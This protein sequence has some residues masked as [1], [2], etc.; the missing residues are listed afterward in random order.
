MAVELITKNH[1]E[2]VKDILDSTKGKVLIISPFMGENTCKEL[3]NVISKNDLTC[4]VITRFYREDF[5]QNVS[6]LDGLLCLLES[7][8]DLRSLK[9]LHTKLYIF[10]DNC[11]IITS[12]NY[13]NGGFFSNI[14]LG[15]KIDD[16]FEINEKCKDYFDDLWKRI[17]D[18]NKENNNEAVITKELI[19][20]EK[21][22]VK[23]CKVNR[24]TGKSTKDYNQTRRGAEL[25]KIHSNDLFEEAL[26]HKYT[27][28]EFGGWLKFNGNSANRHDPDREYF[29]SARDNLFKRTRIFSPT[30]PIG[31]KSG[32]RIFLA[33]LSFDNNNVP[34]AMIM[35][36]AISDNYKIENVANDKIDEWEDWME[37]YPYFVE[38]RN[39]E[40]I[41]G[42][43]K[44][45]ISLLD[46]LKEVKSNTYP[47]TLGKD[48]KFDELKK[49]H[50][51]KDKI[52]ITKY[53][54][55][56]L[57]NELNK[58]FEIHGKVNI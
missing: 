30:R 4:K 32:D 33:L 17:D 42:P 11:S 47:N 14:E 19:N 15:I 58:R 23:K 37:S 43:V 41:N 50:L 52:R 13:T 40:I 34:T 7:G 57:D 31:I 55:E 46:M 45:G 53:A 51:Q 54:Q 36:R 38:L 56:Y 48:L 6:S 49:R 9:H 8:A 35:G 26:N 22:I 10:D 12:A 29:Y 16:E 21:E 20:E 44:N 18:Y 1:G 28:K 3:S 2:E 5:I 27:E 25:G 24:G 39:I